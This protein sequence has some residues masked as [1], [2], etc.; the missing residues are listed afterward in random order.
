MIAIPPALSN[1]I[2]RIYFDLIKVRIF[3]R[4]H[5]ISMVMDVLGGN[6]PLSSIQ[7]DAA[8]G[9][10][11]ISVANFFVNGNLIKTLADLP[12]LKMSNAHNW[13]STYNS[14]LR[15]I[16]THFNHEMRLRKIILVSPT[17]AATV[18]RELKRRFK[19]MT[20]NSGKKAILTKFVNF[21]LDYEGMHKYVAYQVG[22]ELGIDCCPYCNRMPNQTIVDENDNGVIR[23]AFDHFLSQ[24]H[25]PFLALSFFNLVPCCFYCNTSLKGGKKLSINTHLNPF[26]HGYGQDCVF[27][28]NLKNLH[29][30]ISHPDNFEVR[31]HC[32]IPATNP[33]YRRI[34][35]NNLSE[36]N[37]NLFK[38]NSLYYSHRDIIGELWLKAQ[39]YSSGHQGAL[40][41]SLGLRQEE[42]EKFYRLYFGNYRNEDDF[43]KRPLS[44][45]TH[46]IIR[47]MLPDLFV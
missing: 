9:N 46:D 26:L 31:L 20:G 42:K 45:L 8:N 7:H 30:D 35:G 2:A 33:K 34:V 39:K 47:E 44:K 6:Q 27:K 13:V 25:Y 5:L 3:E 32:V 1:T 38:L 11:K 15:N 23:P 4:I 37:I 24:S 19:M 41:T 14:T 12:K 18:D 16:L 17:N 36:G 28:A 29:A 40:F 21:I 43:V 10:S 22:I